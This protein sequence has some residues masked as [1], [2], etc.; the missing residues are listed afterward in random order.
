MANINLSKEKEWLNCQIS[1]SE[2]VSI[3]CNVLV[4]LS[5]KTLEY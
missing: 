5:E 3:F 4:C 1:D 2:L